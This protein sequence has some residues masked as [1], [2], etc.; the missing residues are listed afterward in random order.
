MWYEYNKSNIHLTSTTFQS[1]V[2][3]KVCIYPNVQS[4]KI[5]R[6]S[7]L[8]NLDYTVDVEAALY[9]VPSLCPTQ[10]GC[11]SSMRYHGAAEFKTS[12]AVAALF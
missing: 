4:M 1:N 3:G 2:S 9:Q 7:K 12:E 6:S 11:Y 5:A 10:R 8:P